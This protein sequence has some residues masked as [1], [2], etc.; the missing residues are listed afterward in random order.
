MRLDKFLVST[1]VCSRSEA[2]TAIKKGLVKID[3]RIANDP[4]EHIDPEVNIIS[5]KGE[6]LLYRKYTYIMLNKPQGV[7]SATNDISEKTVIDL[8]PENLRK[9]GLF[10]C[11]RL[12]KNTVGLLILT[13]N[14]ELAHKLLPPK[15]KV[16]KTY[17]FETKFPLSNEDIARL[18]AGVD[19]GGYV[20]KPCKV[21]L[22]GEKSGKITIIEGK[23]HQIKLMM[24]AVNN[25]IAFLE[26]IAFGGIK[27]DTTLERGQW[28]YLSDEEQRTLEKP[29]K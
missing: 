1:G 5:Y 11:G 20:T 14:G 8:L 4:T 28:R 10:P 21:E 6:P 19:I 9:I 2:K 15:R 12:D 26:R 3:S 16:A 27:L 18:E 17:R 13:N 22:E 29:D 7:V 25:S 24:N 23:Y